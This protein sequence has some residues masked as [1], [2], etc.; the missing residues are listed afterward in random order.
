MKKVL[1]AFLILSS[2]ATV[3]AAENARWLLD[4]AIA[5]DGSAIAFSYKGD[6]YTV[7]VAGGEAT[8]IT[9]N[10]A[11][12]GTPVWTPDGKKI[13]FMSNREG[14]NDIFCTNANGGT[15]RRITTHSGAEKPLTFLNDSTLLF[16]AFDLVGKDTSRPPFMTQLYTVNINRSN[17]RPHLFLSLPVVSANANS[18]GKILYQDR[19]GV[20]DVLRKH[21]RSA[22]T[23][24]VWLFDNGTFTQLT[25]FNGAD[26]SPVWGKGDTY[27]FVSEADGTLNVYESSIGSKSAKQLTKF[28]RHPVRSLSA[29]NNGTLAF[30]WD[31]DIYTLRPGQQPA[32][33]N[34]SVNAD[35]YDSDLVKR[36]VNGGASSLAVSPEGK[37]VAFVL[38]GDVYVTSTDYNTTKRITNTP[39]QERNMSFSPDGRSLVFDS[40]VDGHWQLFI[41][42][43]KDDK[44]KEFAYA[45]DIVIEPLYSCSTSAQQPVFSPDGK[46]VAFLEN[47]T[48]LKVIDVDSKAVT[49]A[50][51]GKYNYSYTDGDVPFTWNPDS[52]WLLVSTIGEG[53]WNNIDIALVKADGSENINLT[54]SGHSAGNPQWVLDGKAVAFSTSKYGMK[55]QGSWGNQ[56]DVMLMVLDPDTWEKFNFT[57]EEAELSEK[58]EKEKKEAEEKAKEDDKD[59][60]KD[61]KD[62]KGKKDEKAAKEENKA[63]EFDLANRRYRTVRLTDHSSSMGDFFLSPKGDKLY[64]VSGANTGGYDIVV[65]EIKKGNTYVLLK[66]VGGGLIPDK[67]GENLFTITNGI[68]KITLANSQIKDVNFE[69]P[70]DRRPSLER[71][72]IFDHMAKQVEDKFYDEKLHGVDWKYYVDHYREFLPYINNNRDFATLLSEILGELNASHTGGRYYGSGPA[73]STASLGAYYDEN[74]DGEGLKVTEIFPRGPLASKAAGIEPGDIIL[75]IDGEKILPET[76]Y[77]PLLEGKSG[78]KVRLEV[79][80]ADG[81]TVDRTVKATNGGNQMEM[82]YQRWVERNEHIADSISGGRIGY[83]HVRGMNGESYQ[84]VYDRILGKYRN[85]DAIVVDTRHNGGGWLHNDLAILLGGHQYVTYAPRGK[86]IGIE[87]FAQWTKPSVMLVNESNYSDAHGSPFAYQTLGIGEVIGTP[88]PGTMTAVWWETQIDPTII[89]GIPQVTSVANDGTVLENHQLTPDIIIYNKPGDVEK[90]IDAQLEGA[91]RHLMEKTK[92]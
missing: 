38:R 43:I 5:P 90:G 47:R 11:Y 46:K 14:S 66:G 13:V 89:F 79:R 85:C 62:K 7:P 81:S 60:K 24:D 64:Y 69:A 87:P 29:A 21:E 1:A 75:S 26:Q 16:T 25:D 55:S 32:K 65:K 51:D 18:Q 10:G 56:Q 27:Y 44:E 76:D 77:F 48:E 54:E 23:A 50:L 40:D 53:G 82:A 34:V 68:K 88:V 74:Y 31:G 15:P 4:A 35:N 49:T 33:V 73:L 72:Y 45:S 19:K 91:V 58:A 71:A 92:K 37:E 28:T 83:V 63:T 39:A 59:K 6:L 36:Y 30:S 9:T 57:E 22:A 42:K 78:K 2:A 86:K 67:K 84:T 70:Y 12:D 61:K 3:S 17:P 41:A 52:Q 80:K 20:E 8:Q